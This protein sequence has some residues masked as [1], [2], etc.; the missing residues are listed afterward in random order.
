MRIAATYRVRSDAASIQ[1]RARAIAV[2]QSVEMP[3]DAIDDP[4][5]L[6]GIVGEVQDIADLGDG[7]FAV[8]IGLAAETVGQDAG[9]LL[10]MLFGNTS[11]HEDVTLADADIPPG[12]LPGPRHGIATLR[13]RLGVPDRA[14]TASALKPQGLAPDRLAAL[15]ARFAE[16]GLDL[17]KDDHGLAD[18]RY[19]PFADRVRACAAAVRR[20]GTKTRYVPS[21]TGTLD[22]LRAQAAIAVQEGLD[23][24]MLAPM[25]AGFPAARALIAEFPA[26]AFMAHPSMGGLRIA[27]ELLIGKLFPLLGFSTVVFPTHGGRFGYSP[28]TCAAL[29]ANAR[30]QGALPVPAGGMTLA[31]VPEVL[32]FY[33]R[34]TMLLIGGNLLQAREN[35]PREA[36]AFAA[37]VAAH[38]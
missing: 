10:N 35:I 8:R 36:A 22:Q 1:A 14:F 3:L 29:A 18:Q 17:V 28:A 32:D 24:A 26:L 37:A 23:S 9:Q 20:T 31:R 19:S 38:P 33:G 12:L 34:D 15:A 25:V 30:A 11:L 4:A 2:E 5:V 13:R 7:R 6:S 27:P 21:L 16:G